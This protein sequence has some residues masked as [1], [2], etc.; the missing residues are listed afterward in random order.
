[1]RLKYESEK[2]WNIWFSA[3]EGMPL[4]QMFLTSDSERGSMQELVIDQDFVPIRTGRCTLYDMQAH[5]T[6]VD[7]RYSALLQCNFHWLR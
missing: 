7:G 6:L 1:M 3:K 2:A 5:T 4:P